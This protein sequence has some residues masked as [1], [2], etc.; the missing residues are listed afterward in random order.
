MFKPRY[1]SFLIRFWQEGD[2]GETGWRFVLVDLIEGAQWGF[3]SLD[4]LFA[5]LRDQ[6]DALVP[7]NLVSQGD[8]V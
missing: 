8:N 3:V 4:E 7:D 1:R 2:E 6:V 5:F